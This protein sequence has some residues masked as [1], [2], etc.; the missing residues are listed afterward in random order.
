[1]V[2][3]VVPVYGPAPYLDAALRTAAAQTHPA[4]E[5]L[6]VDDRAA[7]GLAQR[8][9]AVLP[10]AHVLISRAPGLAAAR[11]TGIADASGSLVAFLDADDLWVAHKLERQVEV[12]VR[13]E[14]VG[15]A[16]SAFLEFEGDEVT[17]LRPRR[18]SFREGHALLALML[19]DLVIPSAVVCRRGLLEAAGGFPEDRQYFEDFALFQRL[20]RMAPFAF[21]PE[22]LALY[23]RHDAQM[24]QVVASGVHEARAE[25]SREAL[26]GLPAGARLRRRVAAHD[27]YVA[28]QWHRRQ[29]RRSAAI[30]AAA[31][32]AGR[33]PFTVEP[34]AL[35]GLTLLP[36]G[37]ERVLRRRAQA[38]R[39]RSEL[40]PA[41]AA[42]LKAGGERN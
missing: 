42:A 41:V 16:C 7:P 32:A 24:T 4:V 6:V 10:E 18:T 38:R 30:R 22:P 33:W 17:V 20:A 28:G 12:L 39:A 36:P 26:A 27:E 5:V 31:L 2:S 37:L 34:Y 14:H 15:L 3:V 8:V 11:N 21:L 9:R 35:A 40:S 23:R 1:V 19:E 25:L 13:S 29:G